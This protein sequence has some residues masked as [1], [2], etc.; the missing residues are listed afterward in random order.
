[1]TD[2]RK[3]AGGE[4]RRLALLL[5][6]VASAAFV[7]GCL[8]DGQNG[9]KEDLETEAV[10]NASQASSRANLSSVTAIVDLHSTPPA[11]EFDVLC[12]G[13]GGPSLPRE[14]A[15][16]LLPGTDE[17]RIEVEIAPSY[18]SMQVGYV[19]DSNAADHA[20]ENNRSITWL[21]QIGPGEQRTFTVNVS[22]DQVEK[23]GEERWTFYQRMQPPG[24]DDVCYTGG[25]TGE[26]HIEIEA[27]P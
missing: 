7:V 8:D 16:Y 19:L 25:G 27:V 6:L 18:T 5:A 2:D 1:L 23:P 13:G 17:L 22:S 21:P 11:F 3:G 15:A 9:S 24:V 26:K 10:G 14:E 12:Q 4:V 20:S